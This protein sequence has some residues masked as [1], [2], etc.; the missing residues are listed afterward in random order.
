M[1]KGRYCVYCGKRAR[2]GKTCSTY[3]LTVHT[4][5]RM[6]T[7]DKKRKDELEIGLYENNKISND[8]LQEYVR[9][10]EERINFNESFNRIPSE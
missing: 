2:F 6:E 4:K 1:K 8:Q 3:C 9:F 5:E 7:I 10:Q